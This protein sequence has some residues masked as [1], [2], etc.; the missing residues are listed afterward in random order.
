VELVQ[1]LVPFYLNVYQSIMVVNQSF[2]SLLPQLLK[3]LLQLL[4]HTITS[5]HLT[6]F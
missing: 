6:H 1:V 3:L 4:N 5:F 2:H